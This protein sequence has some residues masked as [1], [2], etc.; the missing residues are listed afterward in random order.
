MSCFTPH[1]KCAPLHYLVKYKRWTIAILLIYLTQYHRYYVFSQGSV[2]THC[3]C[4][5]KYDM[6]FVPNLPPSL[7]VKEF[8]KSTNV[9]QSYELVSS[10]TFL[11]LAVCMRTPMM[12]I[13]SGLG[14]ILILCVFAYFSFCVYHTSVS[15]SRLVL[16]IFVILSI[17]S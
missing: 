15:M 17:F 5:G 1:L 10:G 13:G 11:W 12:T 14:L 16:C 9:S 2:A 8:L 3:R 4:G 7:T 6:G